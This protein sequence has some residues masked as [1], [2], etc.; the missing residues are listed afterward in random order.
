MALPVITATGNLAGDPELNFTA[1]GTPYAKFRIACNENKKT[2]QG[3]E[4]L[5]TTWL[6][7][8]LWGNEAEAVAGKLRKGQ[9]IT[10]TGRLAQDDYEK[11]GIT[12]TSFEIKSAQISLPL[13]VEK[14]A[15]REQKVDPWDG[16]ATEIHIP[17]PQEK[18]P[19]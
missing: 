16:I 11:D 7:V 1:T 13:E 17:N 4:T 10:V 14:G 19:F 15:I 3:W 12:R 18:A 2:D 8:T 5:S 9:R 6:R